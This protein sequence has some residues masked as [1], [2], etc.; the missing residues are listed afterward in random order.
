MC[1]TGQF[2]ELKDWSA[3]QHFIDF[4]GKS[5]FVG[6]APVNEVSR[7]DDGWGPGWLQLLHRSKG[8]LASAHNNRRL[9]RVQNEI[10]D[11]GRAL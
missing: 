1:V 3:L 5:I 11:L 8:R 10:E 7:L 2:V 6:K 4:V 9:D